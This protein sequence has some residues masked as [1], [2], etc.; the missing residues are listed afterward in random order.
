MHTTFG[1]SITSG[2]HFVGR[3]LAEV[4][5][6]IGRVATTTTT[7]SKHPSETWPPLLLKRQLECNYCGLPERQSLGVVRYPDTDLGDD[8][9]D[10]VST[11]ERISYDL[12]IKTIICVIQH[13]SLP[14][15]G[16]ITSNFVVTLTQ[17]TLGAGRR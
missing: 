17:R 15:R 13:A 8:L 6:R 2:A 9:T 12:S 7:T 10:R 5:F 11:V 14:A 16:P 1:A 3:S 4:T